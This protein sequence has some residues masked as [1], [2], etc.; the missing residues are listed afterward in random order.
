MA[1]KGRSGARGRYIG[2][3][4][5]VWKINIDDGEP[6]GDGPLAVQRQRIIL[7]NVIRLIRY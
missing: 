3:C 6:R 4:N 1:R 2:I 5:M 7:F